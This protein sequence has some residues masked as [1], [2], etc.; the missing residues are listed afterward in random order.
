M[1]LILLVFLLLIII[2]LLILILLLLLLLL[3]LIIYLKCLFLLHLWVVVSRALWWALQLLR[4]LISHGQSQLMND[5]QEFETVVGVP[6]GDLKTRDMSQVG[7][8]FHDVF[9][10]KVYQS[11]DVLTHL[12]IGFTRLELW[13]VKV[14]KGRIEVLKEEGVTIK[15]VRVSSWYLK[16]RA[17][18]STGSYTPSIARISL[19]SSRIR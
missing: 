9:R 2:L 18:S 10:E 8:T 19:P 4:A 15:G 16:K 13:E 12:L 6:A 5:L 7:S 3:L 14:R 1:S 11:L 17:T